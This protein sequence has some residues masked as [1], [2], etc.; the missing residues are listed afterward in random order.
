MK[1]KQI[2]FSKTKVLDAENRIIEMVG[3]TETNDRVGDH[4]FMS[5]VKLS[6][7]LKNPIV[8]PNHDY[9]SPAIA[10]A[11]TVSVQEGTKL[12]FKIQF[13]ETELGKEWFYLYS[14]KF[15]NASSIGFHPIQYKPNDKGGF[16][17]IEWELLELSLVTV[18]C[19]PEAIQ[20]AYSEGHISKSLYDNIKDGGEK[21]ELTKFHEALEETLKPL[22]DKIKLLEEDKSKADKKLIE[23]EGQIN[24]SGATLSK[25]SI[26]TL[27][28]VVEGLKEHCSSL[29]KFL[30]DYSKAD[31]NQ[32]DDGE[33]PKKDYNEDDVTK[34]VQE[35][36]KEYLKEDK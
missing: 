36:L 15:M 1:N 33:N 35:K 30:N 5:G 27:T 34:M 23:L 4:M 3:S 17:F 11:L 8:L 10:K 21:M 24:K 31:Q 13:A 2:I 22:T 20:R 29:E 6:N 28:K 7:Y 19:N 32:G 26:D 14:N 18:P 12:V 9:E 16:D 25:A